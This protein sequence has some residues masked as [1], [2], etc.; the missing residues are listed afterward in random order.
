MENQEAATK[1]HLRVFALASFLNDMGSDII[2]PVWPLFVTTVLK[3]NMAALGFLDGLGEAL[4]SLSQAASGFVSDR[5]RKRKIFIWTGYL[6]GAVSRLGYSISSLWQHLIPFRVLDRV[7]KIRSAPR[8]AMVADMST[9]RN[10]GRRFGLLRAMDNLGA[11]CGIM[12]SIFFLKM[13]GY[14]L[15]FALAAIPSLIGS[16][17]IMAF[18]RERKAQGSR[19]FKG[20]TFRDFDSNFRRYLLLNTFYALGAFSYSFLLIY[21]EKFGFQVAFVPVLYLIFTASAAFFSFPFGHLSDRVGRKPVLLLAF[22]LWAGVCLGITLGR[23]RLVIILVFVLYGMH[24]GA[25]EPVQKTLV[26]E[27]SPAA[28]RASSL[29]GFQMVIGLCSLPASFIAGLLWDSFGLFAPFYLSLVLTSIAAVLL[30][31]VRERRDEPLP[32]RFSIS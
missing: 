10:R 15:L 25:L 23:S 1:R 9:G 3:A 29:G 2:Y 28:Y 20:L 8:D 4:V 16:L 32:S 11:V 14:R 21:A 17:L 12:I 6:C 24:K 13:L 26:A 30:L 27:L 18:I 31:F 7:G 19:V 5:I 22:L